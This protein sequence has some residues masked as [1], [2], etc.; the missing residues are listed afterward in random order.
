MKR[1]PAQYY[2]SYLILRGD[3]VSKINKEL[4]ELEL[5]KV[6]SNFVDILSKQI[7]SRKPQDFSFEESDRKSC[8]FLRSEQLY[9]LAFPDKFTKEAFSV[10]NREHIRL[11]LEKL[12]LGREEPVIIAK[13]LNS[14]FKTSFT[15]EGIV[16]FRHY[17][18]N[19]EIMRHEDW[20]IVFDQRRE[21]DKYEA[22]LRNGANYAKHLTG[23]IQKIDIKESLRDIAVNLHFEATNLMNDSGYDKVKNLSS[24]AK[25]LIDIKEQL[26]SDDRNIRQHLESLE[27]VR[28]EQEKPKVKAIT[29]TGFVGN[30][31]GSG[32]ELHEDID[33][34]PGKLLDL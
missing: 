25:T 22:I 3:D 11:I 4:E 26:E 20:K 24:I 23:F 19:P 8:D 27:R 9:N 31:T 6:P 16:R 7:I 5:L 12:I 13:L 32:T 29:E 21:K 14:R 30:Y 28:L 1:H 10:F 34:R 17:F 33:V 15:T 18:W 2:I